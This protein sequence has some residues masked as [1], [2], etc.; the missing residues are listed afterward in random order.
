MQD[1]R[2]GRLAG[3]DESVREHGRLLHRRRPHVDRAVCAVPLQRRPGRPARHDDPAQRRP[4]PQGGRR[5]D[6]RKLGPD[7]GECPGRE[8]VGVASPA[9][10]DASP[11]TATVPPPTTTPPPTT[12][13]PP[14][15]TTGGAGQVH[16]D[17]GDL[18][19]DRPVHEQIPVARAA[20]VVPGPLAARDRLRELLGLEELVVSERLGYQD[21]YAIYNPSTLADQHPEWILKDARATSSTSRGAAPAARARSTRPTSAT[22][23]A[24]VLHR[25]L[26]GPDREGVQGDLRRRRGHGHQRRQRSGQRVA[27]I[28]PR[29]GA[30][31]TDAPGRAISRRSWSSCGRRSRTVE[32]AHNASGSPAAAITTA[33]TRTSSAAD[34]GRR[35]INLERG[36]NDGGLT[37]GTGNLVGLRV[38]ALH[39]QRPLVRRARRRPELRERHDRGRVQPGRVLPDQRRKG[40][41]EHLLGAARPTG[42]PAT[43]PTSATRRAADTSGTASG[44]RDFTGGVVLLNEPGAT[45]KTL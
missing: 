32:I 18:A 4:R 34:P 13:P 33:R 17:A 19:L 36:F 8:R 5:G 35:L 15:T 14:S 28:D 2:P 39:R 38:D 3:D 37:G 23:L 42:G 9:K 40:L 26:Q 10:H 43:T 31:M 1:F 7:D 22:R 16:R 25:P 6:E 41:R 27:P 11:T 45:T 24:A 21:A 12:L 44:G 20:A 29:T 30:P